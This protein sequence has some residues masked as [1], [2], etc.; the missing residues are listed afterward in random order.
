MY[1]TLSP[2]EE[3]SKHIERKFSALVHEKEGENIKLRM[4]IE[5][6]ETTQEEELAKIARLEK[7]MRQTVQTETEKLNAMLT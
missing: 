1:S 7:D 2:K 6:L 4:K 3:A 5:K